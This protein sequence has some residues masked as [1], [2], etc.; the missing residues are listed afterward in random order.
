MDFWYFSGVLLLVG[1]VV[2][3][4]LLLLV[5]AALTRP[6]TPQVAPATVNGRRRWQ[7]PRRRTPTEHA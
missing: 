5:R 1:D 7:A 6:D 2:L 3:I 4:M